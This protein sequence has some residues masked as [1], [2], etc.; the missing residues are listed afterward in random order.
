MTALTGNAIALICLDH[1][2]L[3]HPGLDHAEQRVRELAADHGHTITAAL[4]YRAGDPLWI[5]ALLS[6]VYREHASMVI[7]PDST[8]LSGM[9]RAVVGVADLLAGDHLYRYDGYH[10]P[11][12]RPGTIPAEKLAAASR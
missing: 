11:Y 3:D 6:L 2:G 5:F 4:T 9:E 1:P 10:R 8:H 12:T 7:A